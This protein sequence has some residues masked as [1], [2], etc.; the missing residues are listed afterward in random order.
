MRHMMGGGNDIPL[1]I[2]RSSYGIRWLL[3]VRDGYVRYSRG[4]DRHYV[5]KVE[6]FLRWA[7]KNRA[8]RV[9]N[10][11]ET[12]RSQEGPLNEY[13]VHERRSHVRIALRSRRQH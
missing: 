6:T 7:R 11:D 1:G 3:L 4:G 5:C 10:Q 8:M 12:S 2:Y 9:D 13:L